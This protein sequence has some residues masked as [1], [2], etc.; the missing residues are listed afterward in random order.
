MRMYIANATPQRQ[1]FF[2]RTEYDSDQGI[3]LH[4]HGKQAK[5]CEVAPGQQRELGNFSPDVCRR[6]MDQIRV[7]GGIEE[8]DLREVVAR[9]DRYFTWVVAFDSY[10][11]ADS[12]AFVANA[13]KGGKLEEG[14]YRRE[15]A[16]VAAAEQT[17]HGAAQQ[18]ALKQV[19]LSEGKLNSPIEIEIEQVPSDFED[20]SSDG[21]PIKEAYKVDAAQVNPRG[22]SPQRKRRAA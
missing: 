6:L 15:A 9:R 14:V 13:N 8:G 16:A 2:Y 12:I 5:Q 18:L 4:M 19:P 20:E 21:P 7:Y 1:I 10:V 17:E 22:K 3:P 11:K